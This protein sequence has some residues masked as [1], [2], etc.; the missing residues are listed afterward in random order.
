MVVHDPKEDLEKKYTM[1]YSELF[2]KVS[3]LSDH[4]SK[5]DIIQWYALTFKDEWIKKDEMA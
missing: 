4:Y 2:L 5:E 3:R 1:L